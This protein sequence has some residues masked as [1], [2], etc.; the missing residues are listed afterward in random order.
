MNRDEGALHANREGGRPYTDTGR[1][2]VNLRRKLAVTV[3]LGT[4]VGLSGCAAP[5]QGG[6][7]FWKKSE[8][9]LPA[10]TPDVGKQ[11]YEGL[12]REFGNSQPTTGLGGQ[13]PPASDNFLT[14]S[15]KKATGALAAK[16]VVEE[17]AD[18]LRLDQPAKKLGPEVHVGAAQLLEVQNKWAEAEE[19]YQKALKLAPNDLN[20]LVGLA[21][22][23]DRQGH[24]R[25]AVE[26]YQRALKAHPA[27]GLA[28]NDLG[29]CYARQRQF[30]SALAALGR[31]VEVNPEN[32]KYRNNLALVLVET[33]RIDE[34]VQKLAAGSTPAVA[35]YNVG[36]M[37][38][39]KGL[40][41]QATQHFQQA[42]A[43][44]PSLTPA[45]DMLAQ[46]GGSS[47]AQPI[48]RQAARPAAAVQYEMA[49][50]PMSRQAPRAAYEVPQV[51]V[52]APQPAAQQPQQAP[53]TSGAGYHL[54]DDAPAAEPASSG[55]NWGSYGTTHLP[56]VLE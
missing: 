19:H 20:A 40:P 33:G 27:S 44:D 55:T 43:I 6:V 51:D 11:K 12:A 17:A 18:P 36:F 52:P 21:R 22:M 9:S 13:R 45:R 50:A 29:L 53:T 42:L 49:Q 34:A 47:G 54:S 24:T 5:S 23:H 15:W 7:A 3:L 10:A 28:L 35:H 37:L 8:S 14:A 56:P 2:T 32:P 48:M 26:I 31:A 16:P 25:Q 38:Q 41:D 30:D 46:L 39:Q 1:W 4:G